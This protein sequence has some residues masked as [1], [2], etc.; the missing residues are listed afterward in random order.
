MRYA[1]YYAPAPGTALHQLGAHW[2]G[3]DAHTGEALAQPAID[4]IAGLT[5][6]PRRYGVHATLKAPFA[7]RRGI[8]P[9]PL[10]R[11]CAALAAQVGVFRVR[12]RPDVLDGFLALVPDGDPAALNSLA[13]R[14]VR[15]LDGFRSP[16]SEEELKRRRLAPLNARQ[17]AQLTRWGYPYVLDDF[18]FHMTL[19]HK[20]APGDAERLMAA[21]EALFSPV[22]R[23]PVAI[24]GITLF[25][26]PGPGADFLALRHFPFALSEAEA[27]A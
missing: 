27:A 1:I 17:E 11:A 21:A 6:E 16:P 2:L 14:C 22:L 19:T 7:L 20:L 5:A 8:E 3:R 25:Q 9:E 13:E 18:R 24:D 10:M 15:E 23:E 12:L 4:G 26:E